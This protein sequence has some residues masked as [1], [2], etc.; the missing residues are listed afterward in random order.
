[1]SNVTSVVLTTSLEG[2]EDLNG[3]P[4]ANVAVWLSERGFAPLAMLDDKF[5]GIKAAQIVVGGGAYN[6]FPNKEFAAFVVGLSWEY[7]EDV[8]LLMKV[9]GSDI[10]VHRPPA[11]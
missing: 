11:A 1:M 10:A 7:P 4:W 5:A 8:V 6:Y 2:T 3:T 9:E